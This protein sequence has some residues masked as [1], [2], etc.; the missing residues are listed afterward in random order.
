V[1]ERVFTYEGP[2]QAW[3][4]HLH[5]SLER[6]WACCDLDRWA[7]LRRGAPVPGDRKIRVYIRQRGGALTPC[8]FE[9]TEVAALEE[10]GY[11]PEWEG[12]GA[13]A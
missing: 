1:T 4:G 10:L 7:A 11:L 3:C 12:T 5:R 8:A 6:A 13:R 9:P 2:C